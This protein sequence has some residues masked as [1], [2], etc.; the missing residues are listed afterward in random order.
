[1]SNMPEVVVVTER[2]FVVVTEG[3]GATTIP[4]E[5]EE[6]RVVEVATQG[7]PGPQGAQ[8]NQ[9]PQGPPGGLGG[10]A[11]YV[12][13]QGAP[14]ATWTINHNLGKHPSVTVV[15]S[16]DNVVIGEVMYIDANNLTLNFSAPFGGKAYLN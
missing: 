16:G 2:E 15:D 3:A 7:P 6:I 11:N 1:M 8:G 12:H 4:V 10:D 5:R 13:S 14:S 9:G